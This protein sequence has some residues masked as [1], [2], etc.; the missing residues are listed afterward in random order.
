LLGVSYRYF[1]SGL[2][3]SLARPG[4]NITGLTNQI[5]T[6]SAKNF[7]LLK[8]I[9]PGITRVAILFTP[10]NAPSA[11]TV[12]TTQEEIAPRLGLTV[13]P[14]GV[15]K[16]E[17]LAE[18]FATIIRER[19]EALHVLPTPVVFANRAK[20]S[21]FA[22][23][24]HLPSTSPTH[25]LA[26]DGLLISYGYDDVGTWRQVGSYVDRIFKGTKPAAL[27]VEQID[28]FQLIINQ[29]TGRAIGIDTSSILS[30]ADEVIE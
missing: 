1:C 29:K 18:A 24:Q 30:R 20:I 23:Q 22:I 15:S 27:P 7:E 6:V 19:T 12:K 8:E 4:G 13:L 17:D 16:P 2:V 14:V 28:R 5:E 11:R 25:R 3:V 26:R 21:E 9:K 10:E